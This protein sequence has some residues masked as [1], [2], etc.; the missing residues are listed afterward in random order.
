M[1]NSMG[2]KS[3][4]GKGVPGAPVTRT[5]TQEE[6]AQRD[7][8]LVNLTIEYERRELLEAVDR[9]LGE[10]ARARLELELARGPEGR[11]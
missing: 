8:T 7:A 2:S 4:R 11:G 6:L 9:L 3:C 1:N 10:P 5:F